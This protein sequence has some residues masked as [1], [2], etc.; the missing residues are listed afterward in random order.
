[1]SALRIFSLAAGVALVSAYAGLVNA[2]EAA[3]ARSTV[4]EEVVVTARKR[5]ESLQEVP[6]AVSA[7]D[8]DQLESQSIQEFIDVEGQIPGVMIQ[9]TQHDPSMA[10]VSIRGQQQADFLLTNDS[11]VGAYLD[12]INM[13]RNSGLNA[14]MFDIERIEVLKGPQGTL[15]G[16]NTTGGAIN[17]ISRKAD[18][19]GT[20]GYVKLGL[21]NKAFTQF[22]GAVNVPLSDSAAA[23][24]ALQKTDQD[25]WGTS[26]YTGADLYDQDEIFLRASV[27]WDPH[28]RVNVQLQADYLDIDEGGAAEKILHPGG[29][30]ANGLGDTSSLQAG[31]ELLGPLAPDFSNYAQL[32]LAGYAAMDGYADGDLLKTD[33]DADVFSKGTLYGGGITIS[34][35][36]T[37]EVELKSITGHRHWETEQLLDLDG[38]PFFILHP[39]LAVDADF[40]SQELQLRGASDRLEWVVGG[41]YS[42]ENGI[43]GSS[44]IFVPDL[45]PNTSFTY[46]EATNSSWALFGQA[47]YAINDRMNLTAGL[48]WTEEKK[49]LTSK[50]RVSLDL[51]EQ[52][53]SA[54]TDGVIVCRVPNKGHLP[55]AQCSAHHSDTFDDP[56]WLIS[57][58]YRVSDQVMVYASTSRSWRGGGQNLRAA[59]NEVTSLPY[60]PETATSYEVGLKGDFADGLVRL[61]AS[62]YYVD[63]EEIQRTI[64]VPLPNQEGV[65]TVLTN[66][67]EAEISGFEVEA[68][69]APTDSLSFF[70]TVGYLDFEYGEF[71]SVGSDGVTIIDRSDEPITLPDLQYSLSARYDG[72]IAGNELGFQVDYVWT[73]EFTTDPLSP[74]Q[75]AVTRDDLG[76]LNARIDWAFANDFTLSLW[77]KNI[78]DEEFIVSTTDIL[79]DLGTVVSVSG[80]PRSYGLT[81]SKTFGNE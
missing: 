58:D 68:W 32:V 66:A 25:G 39:L 61:N 62:A 30:F 41:Y 34:V 28:D 40:F 13:P 57:I 55:I 54:P 6:V 69:L 29:N 48:R 78:T 20:H 51:R 76:R 8:E 80:R 19:E 70:A 67:A 46:G 23:R 63:Y 59:D 71:E 1:M 7:F 15:Y 36:L 81:L 73:D 44:T 56:S 45:A 43:D 17:V 33:A 47:T 64:I 72:S 11:S 27:T 9:Q 21:G 52:R 37:D 38:T 74:V 4:I 53:V 18:Y 79:A 65:T 10:W 42:Y 24:L 2:E 26:R 16:R 49:E 12:N 50:N 5:E 75:E 60:A 77:A 35:D 14:N 3:G 31:I 22:S